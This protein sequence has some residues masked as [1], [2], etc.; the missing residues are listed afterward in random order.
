MEI[1]LLIVGWI[2]FSHVFAEVVPILLCGLG[3]LIGFL[4]LCLWEVI[5]FT[6]R[7]IPW[8]LVHGAIALVWAARMSGRGLRLGFMFLFYL[9]DEWR[10]GS[11]DAGA[12]EEEIGADSRD[13]QTIADAYEQALGL[14][15]LAPGFTQSALKRAYRT[16]IRIAHPDAGGSAAAAQAINSAYELILQTHG[17][18][19]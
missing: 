6:A 16:A 14:L 13:E 10:R 9:A 11:Q 19:R 7:A 17:W 12:A 18:A 3:Y 8:L 4:F 2:I 5:K 15:G 1:I